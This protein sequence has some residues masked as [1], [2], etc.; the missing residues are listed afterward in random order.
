MTHRL[1]MGNLAALMLPILAAA[2]GTPDFNALNTAFTLPIWVDDN[3]WDDPDVKVAE[4]LTWP[5]E[6]RTST[7]MSWRSYTGGMRVLR[8]RPYSLAFYGRNGVADGLSFVFANK[9]DIGE[10]GDYKKEITADARTIRETLTRVLG[11][12]K[13]AQYGQGLKTSE[14]VERWDWNGHTILLAAPRGEYVVVRVIPTKLADAGT[15]PRVSDTEMAARLKARVVRR[16]NGDVVLKD[17]PMV[18]QGPKGY[19]VPATWERVLRYMDIP[20]DMYVLAMAGQTSADGGDSRIMVGA[21]SELVARSGRRLVPAGGRLTPQAVARFIDQGTPIMWSMYAVPEMETSLTNRARVRRE[22]TD[23]TAY[24][25]TLKT[26]RKDARRIRI[27]PVDAHMCMIIGYNTATGE[28]AV[29]DSYGPAYAERW[30]TEEEANA[31]TMNE[32]TVIGK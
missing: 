2:A 18:N 17:I 9:G 26:F 24:K 5:L 14:R 11:P 25:E 28:L 20:A 7:D 27:A 31:I 30:I 15:V 8:A 1:L 4:R 13:M 21:V 29:S 23:W 32:L 6:S 10:S 16:P 12:A 3:L 22:T 19:C